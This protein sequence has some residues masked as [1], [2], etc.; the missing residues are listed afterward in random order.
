MCALFTTGKQTFIQM[1]VE[2]FCTY[3]S[4]CVIKTPGALEKIH[5]KFKLR[6]QQ[7]C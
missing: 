5:N 7:H 1:S 3:L 6:T 4:L 2:V